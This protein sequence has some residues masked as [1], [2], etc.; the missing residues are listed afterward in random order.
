MFTVKVYSQSKTNDGVWNQGTMI[1]S[2]KSVATSLDNSTF[3]RKL[4]IY[5]DN[6][7][8]ISE[9]Y[10]HPKGEDETEGV[11]RIIIENASGQTTDVY[12]QHSM[13]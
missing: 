9:F 10:I 1:D 2:C 13:G 4:T 6:H 12:K 8:M 7:E 11:Y 5:A 3:I